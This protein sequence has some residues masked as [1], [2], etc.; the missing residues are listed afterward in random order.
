MTTKLADAMAKFFDEAA[1]L[2]ASVSDALQPLFEAGTAGWVAQRV[3][4]I[5]GVQEWMAGAGQQLQGGAKGGQWEALTLLPMQER[6]L[7]IVD[8]VYLRYSKLWAPD[9]QIRSHAALM[10]PGLPHFLYS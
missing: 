2:S 10:R 3:E 5:S 6:A 7:L 8:G 1:P 4:A 9:D